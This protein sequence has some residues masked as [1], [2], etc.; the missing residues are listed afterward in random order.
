MGE[1]QSIRL[2]IAED[3]V[4]IREVLAAYLASVPKIQVVGQATDGLAAIQACLELKPDVVLLDIDMP[5]LNGV[6]VT[7][8]LTSEIPDTRILIFTS[9]HDSATVRQALEAGARGI[10][11]KT[12]PVDA[13]LQAIEAVAEGRSYFGSKI[14]EVLQR[15]MLEPNA[16]DPADNLTSREREILQLVAEGY[17]NKEL[18][19]RLG[20][21]LRT[22]ENHR[23]NLMRKLGAHNSADLTREAFRMV[24]I[25]NMNSPLTDQPPPSA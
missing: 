3:H 12:G 15:S 8:K 20:I 4:A 10:I 17:S 7:R 9:H 19:T 25:R 1:M 22:V 6:S 14:T 24:L 16:A 5:G 11:E 21:S 13:L 18:C 23:H 2:F